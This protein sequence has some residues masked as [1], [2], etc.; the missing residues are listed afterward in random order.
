MS[1]TTWNEKFDLSDVLY[2]ISNIQYYFELILKKRIVNI[3]NN[4]YQR[5]IRV[6]YLFVSNTSFS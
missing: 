4:A 3:V 1:T 6:L 2:S 5:D